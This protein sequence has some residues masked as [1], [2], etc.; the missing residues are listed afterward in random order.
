LPGFLIVT[1]GVNL[2]LQLGIVNKYIYQFLSLISLNS[3]KVLCVENH[4][5]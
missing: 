1:V 5:F 4:V 3:V 2:P